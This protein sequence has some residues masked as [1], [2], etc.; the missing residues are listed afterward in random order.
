M[1]SDTDLFL[2]VPVQ[3]ANLGLTGASFSKD[4]FSR[5]WT[6]RHLRTEADPFGL[7]KSTAGTRLERLSG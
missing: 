5:A 2:I 3:A 6:I 4:G 7:G 1:T